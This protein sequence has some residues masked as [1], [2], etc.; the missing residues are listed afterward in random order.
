[1]DPGLF[2]SFAR[3]LLQI[4][5]FLDR[6]VAQNSVTLNV[7][8]N[9]PDKSGFYYTSGAVPNDQPLSGNR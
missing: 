9:D 7:A 2:L 1:M 6:D 8:F 5:L 3:V 4:S